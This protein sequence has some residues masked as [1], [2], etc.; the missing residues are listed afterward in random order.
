MIGRALFTSR[1][2][3]SLIFLVFLGV[4]YH[5]FSG[6]SFDAARIFPQIIKYEESGASETPGLLPFPDHYANM[7]LQFE[8][9]EPSCSHNNGP[10][11]MTFTALNQN[12]YCDR[13]VSK[14][15][16]RCFTTRQKG[17]LC[18]ARGA[19]LL[20]NPVARPGNSVLT[21][22]GLHCGLRDFEMEDRD[23]TSAM[24]PKTQNIVPIHAFAG[25]HFGAG[26]QQ[27]IERWQI[28]TKDNAVHN[29]TLCTAEN[30]DTTTN[31]LVL[32]EAP[33]NIWHQLAELSQLLLS[34]DIV[35][36]ARDPITNLPFLTA[37]QRQEIQVIT[38]DNTNHEF[39]HLLEIISGRPAKWIGE[40][41]SA[42]LGQV[43]LP[44]PGSLSVIWGSDQWHNLDCR[45]PFIIKPFLNK[46]YQYYGIQPRGRKRSEDT[47]VITLVRRTGTRKLWN[48]DS[49]VAKL[50]QRYPDY[51]VRIVDWSQMTL[52]EQI[53]VA[54]NTSVLIG[55]L[56]QGLTQVMFLPPEASLGEIMSL[57][58]QQWRYTGFRNVAKMLPVH[59]LSIAPEDRSTWQSFQSPEGPSSRSE[60]PASATPAP[61]S[62]AE[63]LQSVQAS[64]DSAS[65]RAQSNVSIIS[66]TNDVY[67]SSS[68]ST[69][70]TTETS[71][72]DDNEWQNIEWVYLSETRFIGFV[73]AAIAAQGH[74][75]MTNMDVLPPYDPSATRAG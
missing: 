68:S 56:G 66:A 42:C 50:R 51:I 18:L 47:T 31:L 3:Q 38:W 17:G 30:A 12:E 35:Q 67:V 19:Q 28:T 72:R 15:S 57:P 54:Q 46:I 44:L 59:Y 73:D 39:N 43:I 14:S 45:N 2:R 74:A 49:H 71:K 62:A 5:L 61:T 29:G 8:E 60:Q 24:S 4:A 16:L 36:I 10:E 26:M 27:Q 55:V 22:M 37:E 32:R 20:Q 6:Y 9:E 58:E 48:L 69:R 33:G 34:V 70:N 21:S 52:R 13:N 11:M 1:L 23:L 75:G 65:L 7:S 41:E 64:V 25:S 63:P 53:V 40:V